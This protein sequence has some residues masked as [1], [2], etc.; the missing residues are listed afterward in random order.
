MVLLA[1]PGAFVAARLSASQEAT[2]TV[3]GC[4]G[5]TRHRGAGLW[6]VTSLAGGGTRIYRLDAPASVDLAGAVGKTAEAS[7]AAS[8]EKRAGREVHVLTVK[9]FKIVSDRCQ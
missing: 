7:G 1:V 8:T 4:V 2:I 3:T 5:G 6:I 9:A